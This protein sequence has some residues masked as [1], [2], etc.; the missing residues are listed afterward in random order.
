V[1]NLELNLV[2]IDKLTRFG[3]NPTRLL[4]VIDASP[5]G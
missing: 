3:V 2:T 1:P 5:S 4:A